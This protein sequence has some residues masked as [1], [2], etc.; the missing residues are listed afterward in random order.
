MKTQSPQTFRVAFDSNFQDAQGNTLYPDFDLDVIKRENGLSW[1]YLKLGEVIQGEDLIGYDALVLLLPLFSE[2][3]VPSDGKL[4]LVARF[5]VGYDTVDQHVCNENGIL[6][7]NTPDAVRRPVAVSI[8]SLMLA[9][10]GKIFIKDRITRGGEQTWSQR[11]NQMGTGLV[12]KTLGSLGFGGIAGEMFRMASVY[13]MHFISHDPFR[14][15]EINQD[16]K[17]KMVELEQLFRESDILCINCDLNP[18][19][20]NL[21]DSNLLSLMKPTS[22]F[23]NTA[24]GP[25]VNQQDLT[26]VLQKEKIAGAG[27]D[28]LEKEPPDADDPILGLENVIF[29][30]HALAWT[31]QL[32]AAIGRSVLESVIMVK[33]GRVPNNPVNRDVLQTN[34]FKQKIKNYLHN[35]NNNP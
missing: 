13:D 25:I 24:R 20:E 32:F 18:G 16:L 34:L 4:S 8:M 19:T 27:L 30:P 6:L 5:G 33:N 3:L 15:T 26:D 35:L 12:G 14:N 31:D 11:S 29:A 9:L 10:T 1:D 17:V 2:K 23:I 7:T 22:F 28:V 21:V